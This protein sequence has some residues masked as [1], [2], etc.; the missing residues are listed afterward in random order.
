MVTIVFWATA[1]T[2]PL[3]L[4][5]LVM[6]NMGLQMAVIAYNTLLTQVVPRA[7][8]GAIVGL[9]GTVTGVTGGVAPTVGLSA[10]WLRLD[11]D[12]LDS[13]AS[14]PGHGRVLA[15]GRYS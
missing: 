3:G 11:S 2:S 9:V 15:K 13:A 14:G 5:L 8:R 7:Y 1:G 12:L 4:A 6:T 10:G